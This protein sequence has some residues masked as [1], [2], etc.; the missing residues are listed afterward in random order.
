[1]LLRAER[2][3]DVL[4]QLAKI[5]IARTGWLFIVDGE[6]QKFV[7]SNEMVREVV[8]PLIPTRM[9]VRS[10]RFTRLCAARHHIYTEEELRSAPYLLDPLYRDVINLSSRADFDLSIMRMSCAESRWWLAVLRSDKHRYR[11][12]SS[13]MN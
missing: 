4:A 6:K 7:G 10:Q 11:M 12:T 13:T 9:I 2:W 1:M 8:E 3:P 5:A